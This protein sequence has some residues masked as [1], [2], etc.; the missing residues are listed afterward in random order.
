MFCRMSFDNYL[1]A[2]LL[3]NGCGEFP[4]IAQPP[5]VSTLEVTDISTT[6]AKGGRFA[7]GK[8][9]ELNAGGLVWSTSPKPTLEL[10]NGSTFEGISYGTLEIIIKRLTHSTPY[11]R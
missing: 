8:G 10:N 11:Y 9:G 1:L 5:V 4:E 2:L 7:A 3:L 6:T